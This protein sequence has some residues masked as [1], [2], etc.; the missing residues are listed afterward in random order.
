M[1]SVA[2]NDDR[3]GKNAVKKLVAKFRNETGRLKS[4]IQVRH[5]KAVNFKVKKWCSE[6]VRERRKMFEDSKVR[7]SLCIPWKLQERS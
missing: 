7:R 3:M 6:S 1:E 5:S 4:Q 2:E